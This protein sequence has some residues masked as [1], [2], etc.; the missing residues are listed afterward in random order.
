MSSVPTSQKAREKRQVKLDRQIAELGDGSE[1][2]SERKP[3]TPN[4]RQKLGENAK[5]FDSRKK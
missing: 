4:F 5:L 2:L 1:D 3:T